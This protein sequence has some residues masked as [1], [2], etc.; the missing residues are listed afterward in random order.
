MIRGF[1]EES[2]GGRKKTLLVG[3]NDDKYWKVNYKNIY[4]RK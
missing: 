1:V 3:T 4:H 2:K